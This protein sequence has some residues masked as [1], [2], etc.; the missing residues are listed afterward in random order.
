MPNHGETPPGP[1][2]LADW[3][4]GA[5]RRRV[6][7]RL[8][9]RGEGWSVP[10]LMDD[11][12]IGRAWAFEVL[13]ALRSVGALEKVGDGRYRFDDQHALG[14]SITTLMTELAPYADVVVDRPPSR[15][16]R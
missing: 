15:R 16:R 6:F 4:L 5:K 2:R 13:R 14:A 12:G 10:D 7:E 8:A 9:E 3:M 1:E 11:L